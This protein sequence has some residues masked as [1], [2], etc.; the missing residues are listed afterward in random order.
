[1]TTRHFIRLVRMGVYDGQTF[2]EVRPRGW[3]LGGDPDDD[4]KL[5]GFQMELEEVATPGRH[6]PGAVGLYHPEFQP[7]LGGTRFY[8]M[9]VER[10]RMDGH[11]NVFGQVIEGMATVERIG[12][13]KVTCEYC[14]PRAYMPLTPVRIL[15]IHF[16]VKK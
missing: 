13:V 6:V 3:I 1:M 14:K 5:T 11:Y 10:P 4:P 16:E 12:A 15:D 8:V 2:H 7:D 9:L